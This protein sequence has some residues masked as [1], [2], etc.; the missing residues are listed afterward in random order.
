MTNVEMKQ[1]M[2]INPDVSRAKT[3]KD[4]TVN[5]P[6]K[7]GGVASRTAEREPDRAKPQKKG[8]KTGWFQFQKGTSRLASLGSPPNL[9]GEFRQQAFSCCGHRGT[10]LLRL[11]AAVFISDV[12]ARSSFRMRAQDNPG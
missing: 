10:V 11:G 7:L 3:I 9:G 4:F 6:P 12:R 2:E 1:M 8:A 5:T